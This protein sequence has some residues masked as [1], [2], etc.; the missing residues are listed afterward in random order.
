MATIHNTAKWGAKVVYG[1][2]DSLFVY[3]PGR[4]KEQAFRIGYDIADT[5]TAMNPDPIKLKFEKVRSAYRSPIINS[6]SC[7]QVYL[8]SVLMAK[9]RYVGFKYETPDEVEP[10]FEAKGIET[11]RR[12]FVPATQKMMETSIKCASH[13]SISC[14]ADRWSGCCFAH[15][16]SAK[17]RT[18]ASAAG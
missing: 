4:T 16:I 18:T 14:R 8:P 9:K 5:I 12:D 17:S 1:D 2:T 10:V 6:E 7:I 11:V 15:K 3:L 13:T